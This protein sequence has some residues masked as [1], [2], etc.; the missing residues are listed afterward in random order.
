MALPLIA[1]YIGLTGLFGLT[2]GETAAVVT[3]AAVATGVAVNSKGKLGQ[4]S[5]ASNPLNDTATGNTTGNIGPVGNGVSGHWG[6][7]SEQETGDIEVI[8]AEETNNKGTAS[9][10]SYQGK[11]ETVQAGSF[12]DRLYGPDGKPAVDV[13][14]D[15]DHEGYGRPH[16]HDWKD[17]KRTT[18]R[19]STD[20]ETSWTGAD[21]DPETGRLNE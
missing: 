3:G 11:P 7:N 5:Q 14:W 13:D 1:D 17:G 12:Q 6:V 21:R 8:P 19:E 20:K 9:K 10:P 18:G 4:G 15:S 16:S 2:V